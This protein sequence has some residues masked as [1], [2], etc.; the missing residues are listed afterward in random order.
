VLALASVERG[1]PTAAAAALE[2]PGGEARWGQTFTW[3]D[4]LEARAHLRLA[5]GDA[6]GALADALECGRR[7][8]AMGA[9]H[10][11]V[12]AWRAT[13]ARAA[14]ALGDAEQAAA[15]ADADVAEARRFGAS[16]GLGVALRTAGTIAGGDRGI[17]LLREAIAVLEPSDARLE[18]AHAQQE[19]GD[20]LLAADHRLAAREPL[21]AALDT[22]VKCGAAPLAERARTGLVATG[23]RPRRAAY[24]GRDAL[25]PRELRIARM[26][27]DGASN[28]EIAEALFITMKTVETHLGHVYAKLGVPSRKDLPG[29]LNSVST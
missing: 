29:Y 3:N 22:A 9:T 27:A 17:A 25:T 8:T 2:L 20:Q 23:A 1:E 16:W 5:E 28:R 12:V 19:L 10:P 4:Y 26:A 15:L 18:L 13:A 7:L 24:T 14:A 6:T 11:S 21:R